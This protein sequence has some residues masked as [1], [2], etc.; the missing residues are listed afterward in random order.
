MQLLTIE[1]FAAELKVS[2]RY[3]YRLARS[4]ECIE[5]G[6]S[7]D[8]SANKKLNNKSNCLWR[9]DIDEYYN[10]LKNKVI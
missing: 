2:K 10:A 9:I 7:Y 1:E 8:V 6:I 5:N 3:A 4:T